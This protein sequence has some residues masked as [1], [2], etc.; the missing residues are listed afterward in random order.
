MPGCA[1]AAIEQGAHSS[2]FC[3][4]H[5]PAC[6]LAAAPAGPFS[7]EISSVTAECAQQSVQDPRTFCQNLNIHA[8]LSQNHAACKGDQDRCFEHLDQE[9]VSGSKTTPMSYTI[10]FP[11]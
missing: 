1:G 8:C 7:V 3:A 11:P 5:V 10:G 9:V 4:G 2:S 6:A